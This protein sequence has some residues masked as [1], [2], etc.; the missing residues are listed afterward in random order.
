[1]NKTLGLLPFMDVL[2][3]LVGVVILIN[4]ILALDISETEKIPVRVVL[5]E[6]KAP[7]QAVGRRPVYVVCSG[8]D[9]RVA[10]AVLPIPKSPDQI[11][12]IERAIQREVESIGESA[13]VLALVRP[14]GY[15]AFET[16]RRVVYGLGFRFGYEPVNSDWDI[17]RK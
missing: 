17:V 1:M 4:I 12:E 6:E 13:H 9:I 11:E 10:D 16:V 8:S 2:T 5:K 7:R 3:G 15:S 14:D